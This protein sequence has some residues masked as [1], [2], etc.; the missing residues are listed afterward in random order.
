MIETVYRALLRLYPR[1][2]RERFGPEMLATARALDASRRARRLGALVDAVRTA[3]ALHRDFRAERRTVIPHGRS[4]PSSGLA[5]DVRFALR[6]LR[7]EPGFALF[8]VVIFALATGANAAL[9]GIADRLLLRGPDHVSEPDRVVRVYVTAHPPGMRQFTTAGVGQVM[10]DV[11]RG[12]S[13]AQAAATYAIN[14]G[15]TGR[16]ADAREIKIGYA[17]ASLFPLLGVQPAIGRFFNSGEDATNGARRVVVISDT[18]WRQQFGSASGVVG[19]VLVVN[20]EP[21]DIVG[22]APKGFTGAELG[23]VDVWAPVN[24]LGPRITADWMRTWS[25]QW[26]TIVIRLR[27]G[28]TRESA[29]Q[30]LTSRFSQ[31]YDGDEPFMRDAHVWV[32]GLGADDDGTEPAEARVV[33]WLAGVSA[34]VLLIACANV[35]N[36]LLARSARRAREFAVRLALGASRL[37]LLRMLIIESTLL[38]LA[39]AVGGLFLAHVIGGAARR[40][41][42]SSIEWPSEPVDVRV[43]LFSL[44]AATAMGL[45][46][47]AIPA[48]GATNVRL[49]RGLRSGVRDGGGRRLRLRAALTII[50]STLSVALL[51]GAGLFVRSV[52]NARHL[53]LGFEPDRVLVVEVSRGSLQRFDESARNAERARRRRFLADTLEDVRA[54]RGVEEATVAVG[55]PFGNRFGVRI[56][57]PGL[58]ALPETGTGGPGISSVGPG[59][60]R[61]MGTRITRGRSFTP[62]DRAGSAPVAIVSEFMART[63][64]PNEDPIGRCLTIDRAA[65]PCTTIVGIAENANRARLVEA[66]KMHVYI[67]IGQEV[68]FG[69]D[70]L[71][72][73]S[74]GDPA[75]LADALRRELMNADSTITFVSGETLATRIAPQMRSWELGTSTLLFSGL[76]A[77]IVSA[78]GTYSLLAY[79]VA[80]RRH[81]IGVRLALGARVDH[82]AGIVVRWSLAMTLA[83]IAFG[84]LIAV[85]AARFMEPLLFRVSPRDPLVFASVAAILVVV[86]LVASLAPGI[87]AARVDP[88]EALRT[89]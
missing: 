29:G 30:E 70:V 53:P 75:A 62:E 16:G 66:P 56:T 25:A 47:G 85:L 20:D 87:R 73:R 61:T 3:I 59:Y 35:M 89:E 26:L 76:L 57:V 65:A 83:G 9:F 86:A 12:A 11:L 2:F 74:S 63:V 45:L 78:V 60:F 1:G 50:Q 67:P 49:S 5:R 77:L 10:Y 38:S 13:S 79:L 27:P 80:D 88:L 14:D 32:S 28:A 68:G 71:L 43:L 34:L 69:G 48:I 7:R 42:L 81:E 64:W 36:L 51:I 4:M 58:D 6:G 8:V 39:G 84:C 54:L 55:M 33:R 40:T 21:Y 31:A 17:S 37:R 72:V 46:V 18:V 41:L 19:R 44:A 52:W 15:T 82:V 24:L 22:V 23:R